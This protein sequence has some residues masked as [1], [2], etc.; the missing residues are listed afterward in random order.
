MHLGEHPTGSKKSLNFAFTVDDN[1]A[2][3]AGDTDTLPV[4]GTF[5]ITVTPKNDAPVE[6]QLLDHARLT[7]AVDAA[8]VRTGRID[9]GLEAGTQVFVLHAIDEETDLITNK[10]DVPGTPVDESQL[11]RQ[12]HF[13]YRFDTT[14]VTAGAGSRS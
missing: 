13:S 2:G 10:A 12:G 7:A 5:D 4:P 8:A 6:I 1:A 11:N 3:G 9:A 14:R